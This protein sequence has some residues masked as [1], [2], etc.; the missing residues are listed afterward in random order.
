[1]SDEQGFGFDTHEVSLRRVVGNFVFVPTVSEKLDMAANL[2]ITLLS[3]GPPGQL[4]SQ[5]GDLD[6]R[7]KTLLNALKVPGVQDLP[8]DPPSQ[9]Q[10]PFSAY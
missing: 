9:D 2:E 7:L 6:N 4:V 8:K 3:P 10:T 5:P 1:V